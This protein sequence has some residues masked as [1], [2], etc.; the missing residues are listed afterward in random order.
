MLSPPAGIEAPPPTRLRLLG[1]LELVVG[2]RSVDLGGRRQRVVLAVLALNANRVVPVDQ[3]VDAVWEDDPPST[4]RSQIQIAVSALR[5]LADRDL[6]VTR[7]PGYLLRADAGMIDSVVFDSLLTAAGEQVASGH[8]EQAVTSLR[9]A[10][11]LWRG[12]AIAG[13]A[14]EQV[15]RAATLLDDR[16]LAAVEE[17][18]RVELSLGRHRELVG[19]LQSLVDGNPLRERPY[20]LLMLALYRSGRQ[21]E[22]L[23]VAR[24]ARATPVAEVGIEPGREL[25]EL[26]VEI[27]NRDPSLEPAG[28]TVAP[29]AAAPSLLPAS[30]SDFTGRA[31][32]IDRVK[33]L[34]RADR[35]EHA[36][37][38]VAISGKGGVGKSALAVRVAHELSDQF[39]DGVL[40]A[41]L[42]AAGGGVGGVLSRFLR[43]LGVPMP[44]PHADLQEMIDAYRSRL[45]GS[46]VLV[47][48]DDVTVEEQVRPLVPGSP[49]CAVITT[50]RSRPS[51]LPGAYW[52]DLDVFDVDRSLD[53]LGRIIGARRV[54]SEVDSAT[55]LARLC[56]GLPLALRIAGARL[57]SRPDLRIR[58][59]VHRLGDEANRLDELAHHG[60]ELRPTL[61][62]SHRGLDEQAQR[63]LR[64]LA[65]VPAG[66]FA[67]WTAAALLD[68]DLVDAENVVARLVDAQLLDTITCP[69]EPPPRYRMHELVRVYARELLSCLGT[70]TERRDALARL[71]GGLLAMAEVLHVREYGGDFLVLHGGAPRWRPPDGDL[72]ALVG[73]PHG[74]WE[75]ERAGLLAA[76]RQAAEADLHEVC[77][78]LALT[79]FGLFES[80]GCFDDWRETVE[81][82]A[83][84]AV[85]AGDD[86]G[87][88]SVLYVLGTI[89]LGRGHFVDAGECFAA[90]MAM[91]DATGDAHG[92]ALVQRNWAEVDRFQGDSD[93]MLA[94]Y[95]D[96]LAGLRQVGDRVGEAQVL[97]RLARHRLDEGEFDAAR[98]LLGDASVICRQ[99]HCPRVEAQVLCQLGDLDLATGRID[100]AG[101]VLHRALLMVRDLDDR[102]GE[103][104]ALYSLGVVRHREGRLDSADRTL[105][106]AHTLAGQVCE[107]LLE[108]R[109]S[110]ALA[111]VALARGER[112]SAR[113]RLGSAERIFD[114]LGSPLWRAKTLTLS[115]EVEEFGADL[116][117]A[118]R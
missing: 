2:D 5:R 94:R 82:A 3:L 43:A 59:L 15:R 46:A 24:R 66:D 9:E 113:H 75:R 47:V 31:E 22:A 49:G 57:A 4:A 81:L 50:S 101:R 26:E 38:I 30:I 70:A 18:L 114:E 45:A 103:A 36:V 95:A 77:W 107:R 25:R 92:R 55:E 17:R 99:E 100:Q 65:L 118:S 20:A 102:V 48:L 58:W 104:H 88:A 14:S 27:L 11:G 44:A 105:T 29:G 52:V 83:A 56:G 78:D 12:P 96:A 16:R 21:A 106:H 39:P 28:G 61:A 98:Q 90:A 79:T 62:L 87:H 33:R 116:R 60:M 10:L 53:L 1:P 97:T 42:G 73:S 41:N 110:Y 40:Y 108:G 72:A 117:Q 6:I 19:E 86:R 89:F 74:W 115:A 37:P 51:G 76:V 32:D 109:A 13:L 67:G 35:D 7:P 91:F 68:T 112:Q 23:D 71:A 69:G 54:T 80:K 34:L 93:A 63:L 84:A 85:R 64:L 8:A 111:E